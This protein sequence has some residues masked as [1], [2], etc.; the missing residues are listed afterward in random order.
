MS[1]AQTYTLSVSATSKMYPAHQCIIYY[2]VSYSITVIIY[3][4][5]VNVLNESVI[6]V[7]LAL[8]QCLCY[9]FMCHSDLFLFHISSPLCVLY[10]LFHAV[11]NGN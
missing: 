8:L 3:E 10:F 11:V 9:T 2:S 7:L 5:V 1:F 6:R 4:F